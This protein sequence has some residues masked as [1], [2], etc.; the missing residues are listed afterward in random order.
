MDPEPVSVSFVVTTLKAITEY[1]SFM[2]ELA[3]WNFKDH[4]MVM[5]KQAII[6][7]SVM[8]QLDGR[9]ALHIKVDKNAVVRG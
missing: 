5:A 6:E 7:I 9:M 2:S 4:V 3:A 8:L 1:D